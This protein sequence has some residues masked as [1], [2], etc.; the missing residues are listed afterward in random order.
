MVNPQLF[1]KRLRKVIKTNIQ[2][3]YLGACVFEVR[4]KGIALKS[5]NQMTTHF[6]SWET[7]FENCHC[8]VCQEN[9]STETVLTFDE[10]KSST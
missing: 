8:N 2:H 7:L 10:T 6:W 5:A 4:K 9:N 3:D 1:E